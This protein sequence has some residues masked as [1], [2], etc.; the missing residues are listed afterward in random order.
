[1]YQTLVGSLKAMYSVC[2]FGP[3]I[4]GPSCVLIVCT[5]GFQT[6]SQGLVYILRAIVISIKMVFE[7]HIYKKLRHLKGG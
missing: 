4:L 7:S 2:Y 3:L 6:P 5:Y 1:M